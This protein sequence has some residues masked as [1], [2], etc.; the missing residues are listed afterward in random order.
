VSF[1]GPEAT[2]LMKKLLPHM[3]AHRRE[4]IE[5]NLNAVTT[6]HHR[7]RPVLDWKRGVPH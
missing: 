1:V 2:K 7:K 4:Q 5:E 3:S 6:T